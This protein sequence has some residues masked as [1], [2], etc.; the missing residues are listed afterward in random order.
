MRLPLYSEKVLPKQTF[1]NSFDNNYR[2]FHRFGK[3]KFPDGGS[4]LG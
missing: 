2:A 1:V 3:T 4:I